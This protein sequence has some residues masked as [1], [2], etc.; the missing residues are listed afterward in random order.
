M[1]ID[2]L[3]L[4]PLSFSFD[5]GKLPNS[6]VILSPR[7]NV[8][9]SGTVIIPDLI[10][11]REIEVV[12]VGPAVPIRPATSR[13]DCEAML[14]PLMIGLVTINT[15]FPLEPLSTFLTVET[16]LRFEHELL[17]RRF[18]TLVKGAGT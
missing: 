17:V 2:L 15:T 7:L 8:H 6:T 12:G 13:S 16:P 18:D 11:T 9:L 10:T 4:T 5:P 14:I 3:K 1:G